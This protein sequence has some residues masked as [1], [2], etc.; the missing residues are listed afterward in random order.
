VFFASDHELPETTEITDVERRKEIE[1]V[2]LGLVATVTDNPYPRYFDVNKVMH[3][4]PEN[5]EP[6]E[7]K[8]T[9]DSH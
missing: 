7:M 1:D 6:N 8:T 5:H 2:P 9:Q 4:P 3:I